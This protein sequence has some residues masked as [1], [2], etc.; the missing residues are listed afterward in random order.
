MGIVRHRFWLWSRIRRSGLNKRWYAA[1]RATTPPWS[2]S[3]LVAPSACTLLT[4]TTSRSR[5]VGVACPT[6]CRSERGSL[7][8]LE[9]EGQ[10][11]EFID[12]VV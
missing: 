7:D 1:R 3:T 12:D 8:R 5:R 9:W 10:I 4:M 2:T 6:S 11:V